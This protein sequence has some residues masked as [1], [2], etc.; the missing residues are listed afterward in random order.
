M[1]AGDKVNILLVD[2]QP[3]KLMSY[4]VI[5]E[6]LDENLIAAQSAREALEVL[7]KNDVAVLLVDVCMPELDGFEFAAMVREH[8]RFQK[9]AIIFIS[10]IHLSDVD[11]L[12]GYEMGAVDYVPVP[13]VPELL[14]AKVRVF[15]DLYRKTKELEHWNAE[16]E[17]RV[18]E[19]TEELNQAIKHQELLAREVDHR[20]KNALAVVQSI[21][22][23]TRAGDI[24]SFSDA[25]HGRIRA[26]AHAHMLLSAS[27]WAGASLERLV[28]EELSPY[29]SNALI[30]TAGPPVTMPPSAAEAVAMAL[31]EL[32]TNAAKYG[33]LS[34]KTGHLNVAWRL[35]GANVVIEWT[36][37][38]GPPVSA[39]QKIGF[40][41]KVIATSIGDQL[42]GSAFFNW[43][44]AGL[45]CVLIIPQPGGAAPVVSAPPPH[46][47][48]PPPRNP[49][50]AGE[51]TGA[52]LADVR[53][54]VVEDEAIVAMMI[55]DLLECEGAI[56]VGPINKLE[57][58]MKLKD[59]FDVAVL[60]LNLNGIATYPFADR[61]RAQGCPFVFATGYDEASI[62]SRFAD[63]E[64]LQKPFEPRALVEAV[65]GARA[66]QDAAAGLVK[67]RA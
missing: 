62:E 49:L 40:G 24:K 18:T 41:S 9:T 66:R 19:R 38:G 2:D 36:E 7:L 64:V 3:G 31:H 20:A 5:L 51:P 54:L 46:V 42:G 43:R 6:Q 50:V 32:A 23:L 16:L 45:V 44:P 58:A 21:V 57:H 63:T 39:P 35:D 61:L 67:S 8:P 1:E 65:K 27:R 60:D 15:V 11:S 52:A 29:Q 37:Q 47:I 25:V 14:R 22:R 53:V 10:A 59:D 17:R 28:E 26:M 30:Q 56:V 13:V 12:R 4:K 55:S 34:Q 48:E 33:A